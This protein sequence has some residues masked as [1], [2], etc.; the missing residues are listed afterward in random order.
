M[1]TPQREVLV[2][3]LEICA[4]LCNRFAIACLG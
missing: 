3:A 4:N 2:N 1:F